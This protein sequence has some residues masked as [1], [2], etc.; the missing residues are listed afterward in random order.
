[1]RIGIS[2]RLQNGWPVLPQVTMG[3]EAEMAAAKTGKAKRMKA[4]AVMEIFSKNLS[5]DY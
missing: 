3:P 5:M 2:Q 4:N 1:M